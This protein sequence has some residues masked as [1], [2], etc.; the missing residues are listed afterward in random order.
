M[1]D[2]TMPDP[3]RGLDEAEQA[4][5]CLL[6]G[7]SPAGLWSAEEIAREIGDPHKAQIALASLHA[8][9]LA[10]RLGGFAFATRAATRFRQLA[11]QAATQDRLSL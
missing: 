11:A 3:G 10:H 6:L 7:P 8:A 2:E 9:G 4:I 1:Q 5:L